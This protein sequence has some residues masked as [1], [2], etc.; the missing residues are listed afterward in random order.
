MAAPGQQF[1][2][3]DSQGVEIASGVDRAVHPAGLFRRHVG[4]RAGDHVWR[5]GRLVLARQ[6]RRD[7]E[8]RQPARAGLG[9]TRMLAGFTSLWMRP[10]S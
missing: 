4:E 7:A 10:R 1:V 5:L 2:E 3:R 8:A 9:S 6:A